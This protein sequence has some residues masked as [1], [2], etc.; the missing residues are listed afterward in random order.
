MNNLISRFFRGLKF[1]TKITL[2]MTFMLIFTGL[3]L[4]LMLSAMSS[5]ALLEEGRKRGMALTSG[6][7]FRLA[8]P[9]LAVDFLQM[10][11]LIDN[12]HTQYA[13]VL[14]IFLTDA[15]GNIVSHT[16]SGGFPTDLLAVNLDEDTLQPI[17]L[18]TE[19]G[20]VYDFRGRII[21]GENKLGIVRLGLSR[22]AMDAQINRQ[23]LTSLLST[24]GVVGLGIL[25]SL[26]FARTVTLRLN[27]LRQS[28]EEIVKGNL[29]VHAGF[30]LE[31]N[32]WE[33]M[34]CDQAQCPAYGDTR[35][36]C[37]YLAGTLCP[38]CHGKSY[39]HKMESCRQCLVFKHNFG[40]EIQDLAEAFDAMAI[41]VKKH[42][43]E[44]TEREKT[45]ARQQ[46][47]LKTIM[48]VTPD[49]ITL[50]DKDLVYRFASKAFCDYFDLSEEDI[51]GKTDFDI[52][53][54]RQ[55]D[56]NYHE[57]RQI[58]ITRQPLTKEITFKRPEGQ[59]WFHVV[60]VPVQDQDGGIM[61]LLL[62]ARDI[63]VLKKFQEQLIQS[64]KMEDLGRL[65][66]GVAHE[67]NTPLGIILG[68]TQLLM[69]DIKDEELLADLKIVE[70][71][72]KVCRKIVAD[73]LGFSRHSH[74]VSEAV[75]VNT[76]LQEVIKLVEH[77]FFL[78]RIRILHAL[79]EHVPT[80]T[81]DR[82]RLKQVWLN[83]LN[84]AADA[85]GQDGLIYVQSRLG[86]K[87]QK[88]EI[89]FT[90]TG[91]GVAREHLSKIFDPFF[92]TK[93]VGKGTGLGLSVSFGIIRE[94]GGRITA[95]SPPPPQY[96]PMGFQPGETFGPGTVF[97]V[98]LP[99]EHREAPRAEEGKGSTGTSS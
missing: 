87:G 13:D 67:I 71:Q 5:E 88:V 30:S 22:S 37:W 95:H 92:T 60:K 53:S 24:A 39:P 34:N 78:N 51:V 81:G 65:A 74:S 47:L 19:H 45:I 79:A 94:H 85:I 16:F 44:L 90:D 8:E 20:L 99:L 7:A 12:V 82:E 91:K 80:L 93:E 68:Y 10:K 26:W 56:L 70:K 55:A 52:F 58:L 17:L 69:D 35:R 33:I 64:Q 98:E 29:D 89:S 43:E 54:R 63:S 77:V 73:L 36:R 6:L 96:L 50:Q 46:G 11:N 14:Y 15:S 84:N 57:D 83:L 40:D 62:T 61:G 86:D 76:S 27:R 23:R 48:N 2:G 31:K 28:A 72:T 3:G 41:T 18:A 21:L 97:I 32:C 66:G 1:S 38:D 25:L 42:I 59:R 4:G 9:I 49:F 75:D